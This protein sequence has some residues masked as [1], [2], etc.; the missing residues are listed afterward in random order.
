MNTNNTT[1]IPMNGIMY[2]PGVYNPP[3][4]EDYCEM[5][6][7]ISH[8]LMKHVIGAK[9]VHFIKITELSGMKYIWYDNQRNVIEIW[10]PQNNHNI[11]KQLLQNKIDLVQEE[12]NKPSYEQKYLD[13]V[14]SSNKIL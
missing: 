10:G 4:N 14:M 8:D 1:C 11:A 5:E 7:T 6:A 13:S 3:I 9:G 12:F 2:T